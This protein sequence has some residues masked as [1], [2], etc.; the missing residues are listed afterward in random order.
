VKL[1][2][3]GR[4]KCDKNYTKEYDIHGKIDSNP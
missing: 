2:P 3:P 4:E 1:L